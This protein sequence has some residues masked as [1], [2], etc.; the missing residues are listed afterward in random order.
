MHADTC[1]KLR[2]G[3]PHDRRGGAAGGETRNID[4]ARLD[5]EF[6]HDLARNPRDQRG[7]A[8]IALLIARAEPVPAFRHIRAARL[9]RVGDEEFLF[10]RQ[11]VHARPGGKII[12]GL[13]AAMQHDDERQAPA[14]DAG[15]DEQLIASAAL[16]VGEMPFLESRILRLRLGCTWLWPRGSKKLPHRLG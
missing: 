7:L 10:L 14:F 11:R 4:L 2:I 8:G 1:V 12:R 9:R 15:G 5:L 6:A 13:R 16:R 3:R